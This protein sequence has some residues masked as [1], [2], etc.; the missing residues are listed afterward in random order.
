MAKLKQRFSLKKEPSQSLTG[1]QLGVN[2]N[3]ANP[4]PMAAGGHH[5]GNPRAAPQGMQQQPPSAGWG[6]QSAQTN[7]QPAM[8]SQHH[9][10]GAVGFDNDHAAVAA[11]VAASDMSA[12]ESGRLSE[13]R[14]MQQHE[15]EEAMMELA[16]K[17]SI[18][19]CG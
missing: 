18:S 5:P 17:V 13:H 7:P 14:S 12:Q 9:P 15:E 10:H 8:W 4:Y 3:P 16:I 2:P 11:A 6:Y 1:H 19:H